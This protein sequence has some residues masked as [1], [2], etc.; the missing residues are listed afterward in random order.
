MNI[1]PDPLPLDSSVGR[2]GPD[3]GR[4]YLIVRARGG[5]LDGE[6]VKVPLGA[7]VTLGRSRRC[8][9]SLKKSARYLLSSGEDRAEIRARMAFRAVSRRHC[10]IRFASPSVVEITNHSS[11]GT[12]VDGLAVASIRLGDIRRMAHELRLGQSGDRFDV[13]FGSLATLPEDSISR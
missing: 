7:T 6:F 1:P 9:F 10:S 4:V 8:D 12:F 3:A 11:N 2:D 5:L 13:A